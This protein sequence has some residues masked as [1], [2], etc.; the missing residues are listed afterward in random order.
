MIQKRKM[1]MMDI[2]KP[3]YDKAEDLAY[4]VIEE[5]NIKDLPINLK[6][7]IK[8]NSNLKLKGYKKL[9]IEF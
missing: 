4:R 7:I 3:D 8:K 2:F 9:E 1:M 6:L 5:S